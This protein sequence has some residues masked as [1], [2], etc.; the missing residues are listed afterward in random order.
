MDYDDLDIMERE[1]DFSVLVTTI[2]NME[3]MEEDADLLSEWN[4]EGLVQYY[5]ATD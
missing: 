3:G 1:Q 2:G 4:E 5:H